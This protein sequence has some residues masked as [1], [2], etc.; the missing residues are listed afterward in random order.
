MVY[1]I[2]KSSRKFNMVIKNRKSILFYLFINN[3]NYYYITYRFLYCAR[4]QSK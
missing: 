1:N 4:C 3:S 2:H